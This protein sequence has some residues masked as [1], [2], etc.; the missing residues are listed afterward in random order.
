MKSLG[1]GLLIMVLTS[2][3][4][5]YSKTHFDG[6]I[7][8]HLGA[9]G[10]YTTY[11]AEQLIAW[12]TPVVVFLLLAFFLSSTKFRVLDIAGTMLWPVSQCR[13]QR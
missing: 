4:A 12:V 11:L 5:F 2:I 1:R 9:P 3:T 13:W 8:V 7:D 10:N 6:V